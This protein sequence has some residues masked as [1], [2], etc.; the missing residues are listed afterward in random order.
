MVT[1]DVL[2]DGGPYRTASS[3]T[4]EPEATFP[5]VVWEDS[6]PGYNGNARLRIVRRGK[7]EAVA[8]VAHSHNHMNEWQWKDP[9]SAD[10]LKAALKGVL[11]VIKW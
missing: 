7:S 1:R 4:A 6:L 8:E 5:Y 11:G 9:T 3:A 10:E 2:G